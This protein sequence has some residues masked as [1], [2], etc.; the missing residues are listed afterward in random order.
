VRAAAAA[1]ALV[2]LVSCAA[3]RETGE[4]TGVPTCEVRFAAPPGFAPS[5]TFEEPYEDRVGVRL[6]FVDPRRRELHVFAGI[7]GEFGEGLP[8]A[9]EIALVGGRT[10]VVLGRGDVWVVRWNEGDGCDPRA[11]LV[12]GFDRRAFDALLVDAGL[13]AA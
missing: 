2:L 4:P 10:G 3:G 9:G 11:L 13:V 7:P 12:S 5:E 8:E 1:V 6:G